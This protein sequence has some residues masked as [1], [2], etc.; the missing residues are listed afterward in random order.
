MQEAWDCY[1]HNIDMLD[2]CQQEICSKT[3][4]TKYQDNTDRHA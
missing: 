1:P 2:T 3:N 4:K